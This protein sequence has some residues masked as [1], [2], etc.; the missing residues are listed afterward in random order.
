MDEMTATSQRLPGPVGPALVQAVTSASATHESILDDG[1]T[2]REECG[3]F[4]IFGHPDAAAITALGLH[5]LQHRGQEAAGIVSFDGKRFHSERR[6]GLVGDT[7]SKR[8]VID[9]LPGMSACGHVRYST[10]GETL[11]RNVQP[12]FAELDP[13]GFAIG[14]N[15]NLTNGLTL[16]RELVRDGAIMQST[17]DTEVIIHLVAR[18][19]KPRF[20]DRFIEGLRALE[21]AYSFVGLTNKKLVGARDPLG[22]RPLVMGKLEGAYI[23]ASET[24]ALDII[25]AKYVRDIENGEV[26]IIDDKGIHSHKPFPPM[27][28]RPCIFEY[29]YFSR[30]DSIVGGRA[31]H[32]VRK[33]MGAQLAAEAP[34][35]ADVVVPVPDSGVPAALGYSQASGI[36]FDLGIIRNHYVGRTFIEP[37]QQIRALGVRLKHSAN[38]A[39]VN[40]K[41]IVLIDD[42]IVRGTTSTKI[43]QMMRDAGA[44]EVHFR[45]AS[46]PITHPDYY[47]IDTPDRDKLLAATHNLEEMR[48]F[49][50]ADS[51]AF[52]SV[53]GIYKSMGY[54][55]RDPVRPQFTDHCF[56]GEYPTPLTDRSVEANMPRQLSLLAEAS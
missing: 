48:A 25:G 45:I 6:L 4:G 40:G 28:P 22:I 55:S 36:P 56:T 49:I 34:A 26:I 1:D 51:L 17:T 53:E 33:T 27:Q 46:P 41:R 44:K 29:I 20:V 38:R 52:L 50:G 11:L 8:H 37:T 18:S 15:G 13:F 19:S 35:I 24:C 21:G 31:V 7:F 39:V 3:V 32:E 5:A 54:D 2:L 12:L 16:R 23:L 42:S 43:V 47:G 9:R 14:H 30:P 10:T